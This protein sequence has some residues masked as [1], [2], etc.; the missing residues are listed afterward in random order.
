MSED[1]V[2]EVLA[3]GRQKPSRH[4]AALGAALALV[5]DIQAR[6]HPEVSERCRTCAFRK[7]TI[8]NQMAGT[9]V[10]ALRCV[11]GADPAVFACHQSPRIDGLPTELCAGYVLARLAPQ[12]EV[13]EA[14]LVAFNN[15]QSERV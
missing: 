11:T 4:G 3:A 12:S 9:L 10:E 2:D 6:R 7:G 8:P 14:V 15:L 5:A 13:R 1:Y